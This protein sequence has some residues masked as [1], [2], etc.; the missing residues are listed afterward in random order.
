MDNSWDNF[1]PAP[2][3][4]FHGRLLHYFH[5]YREKEGENA[6]WVPISGSELNCII[7]KAK[8][9]TYAKYP[10]HVSNKAIPKTEM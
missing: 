6:R 1:E 3:E 5:E 2:L 10:K 9:D 8:L 7:A 4:F